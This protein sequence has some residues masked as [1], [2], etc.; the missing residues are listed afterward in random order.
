MK[1]SLKIVLR[2][3]EPS[4][5][6]VELIA[7]KAAALDERFGLVRMDAVVDAPE[8]HARQGGPARVRL[9]VSAPHADVVVVQSDEDAYVAV[10]KAFEVAR[11]RLDR[12][13]RRH[14][15]PHGAARI[16][17]FIPR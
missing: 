10:R 15:A 5:A 3:M 12:E 13:R 17:A 11:R 16:A 4:D 1:L 7:A 6:L 8:G 14:R 9:D 2:H